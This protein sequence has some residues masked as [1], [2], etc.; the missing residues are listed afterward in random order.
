MAFKMT[1]EVVLLVK[2]MLSVI[3]SEELSH[4][5]AKSQEFLS[6]QK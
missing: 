2:S 1:V 3:F 5:I 6:V 4:Q